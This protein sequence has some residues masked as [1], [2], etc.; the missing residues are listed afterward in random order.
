MK[1]KGSFY[2]RIISGAVG[3]TAALSPL[4][5]R[6]QDAPDP[7]SS[8]EEAIVVLSPFEVTADSDVG[9]TASQTLAGN[10][11]NTEL[12]D[13]GS[14]VSVVTKEFLQDVGATD[15][16]SLLQYT[17]GTEV[18][19]YRGNFAGV[20]DAAALNEDTIRPS[21]NN[22]VRG[23]A[24]ADNTRD[25]FRSDIPWDAYNVDRVDLQRGANSILFG[26]GSPAGIINT[27]LKSAQ[28]RNFGEAEFRVGSYG[29]MRATLDLNREL[30]PGQLAVRINALTEDEGFRQEEA[31]SRDERLYA[32]LRY[33]PEF[34]NQNGLRT[35]FKANYETGE[36]NSN[37]PRFL[38][39]SDA[40]TPWFTELGQATYNQFQA[41]DHLSGRANHGQF[42]V[43]LAADGSPNPAY[44]PY[45]GTFGFPSAR[46]GP[47]VFFNDGVQTMMVTDVVGAFVSGGIGSDGA[48]DGGIAA[49][50]DNGWVSLHGTAQWAINSGADYSTAGLWKNN[51]MTNDGLFDFYHHLI[52]GD[53]KREWQ[54]FD[55]L[56]LSL[57]QTYLNDRVGISLDYS[58]EN[59]ANGQN[60]LLPGDVRLQVDP[61][62]VYGDGSPSATEPYSDGT[63]N[64][65]VGRAFV[66]TNNAW[67]NR[68][69]DADR[70]SLRAT[71]FAK[72]DFTEG[73]DT[74]LSNLLGSHTFT[75][76]LAEDTVESDSRQWQRY[77]IF[78]DAFY[79]LAGLPNER[80]NGSLTPTQIVYLGDSL[81][82]QSMDTANLPVVTGNVVMTGGPIT[83]FDSTWNSAIDPS[84][85]WNNNFY[86]PGSAEYSSTE[87]ENPANYVGWTTTNLNIVDAN[88]SAANRDRLTTRATLNKATTDSQAL[89]WQ[90][91]MLNNAI[92]GTYGWRKDI[93]KSWAFDM[94]PNDFD[95]SQD[96]GAV[97]LSDSYYHLPTN[98]ARAEVQS[99]SY[100][101]VAHVDDLPVLDRLMDRMPFNLSLYYSQS[102]NFKPDS[103]R[104]D[105]YGESHP[106]PS[107]KTVDRGVRIETKDGKYSLRVNRYV[108]SNYNATS[109]QI[110]AAAIGSWMQLTQN[111]ANVF[112]YNIR[113][114][115]Y[116]A[117]IAGQTAN[118]ED[119]TDG[120]T[121][122]WEP[123]RYNFHLF[124][125]GR[126]L[127]PGDIVS[128]DGSWVVS[129]SLE[130]EV[131]NA[132]R[133][134]QRAV[135]PRFWDA[136]RIDTFGDFGPST[137]EVT[138]SVPTGFA[139]IEDNVSK[140]WEI[141]L[142]AQPTDNWRVAF[143]ASKTDARRTNVGNAHIREFMTLVAD[144][145]R[146][147]DGNGVG[148]LQHFWGTE[149]VVTAGKNWFDGEGLA[150]APG[151]EW[152]LA[153]LVENTTVPELR[154]WRTNLITNY[155]FSEGRLKGFNVG[156]GLR[157]QSSV[158]IAYPPMGDPTDPTTV[159]YNL[160]APV[161]GPAETNVDLWLGYRRKLTD[162]IDWRVQLNVYNAFSGDNKLIPISAQPDGSFA[163][164]R[165]APKRSWTLSNTFEF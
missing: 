47:A 3:L 163:A 19:G 11:L 165:I 95:P 102:T 142:A 5:L 8:D 127:R 110:N 112:E 28:F 1:T 37:N 153:Q 139:I 90:G 25:F 149:D 69:Y 53:T 154:E 161:K 143:N 77:G 50:P 55:V 56:N 39:P 118:D 26:Q 63:P 130:A 52:D 151:S 71:A 117:T 116:D 12:R 45:I 146:I 83:Y 78:D 59:Y 34:L 65:N 109:T 24:A 4:A 58:N 111:Y 107:G 72:Y 155:S 157:Y 132:V 81:L 159:E 91:K 14:A 27:G 87:A 21:E 30:L 164:Y 22:R 105:I 147:A 46:S 96:R 138:Y 98:G 82:G 108:T 44:E 80:F 36:V 121:G 150:G 76:L 101:I 88:A 70:E 123:M 13:I 75:G 42:R 126:P 15:N 84:T 40:I 119:I 9:Y 160:A 140:G 120:A 85:P 61:M 49:M 10:R 106:A 86:Q 2:H 16:A 134:F 64:P 144:S 100:S 41:F 17:T 93:A 97:D 145:L 31:F 66:S 114:W 148:R 73:R 48:V 122:I 67:S 29:T 92:V 94:S 162:R 74:W 113:P 156:G 128:A 35:T 23:L 152:R 6:A 135:D 125:D 137:H 89:V 20:G 141:E 158:I 51:L 33:E 104:V 133:T 43:N 62:A 103:S 129:P 7:A 124:N 60:A 57:S 115:G 99:R 68:S 18:S 38:P 136:W 32:A 79:Q 54:D 131:I